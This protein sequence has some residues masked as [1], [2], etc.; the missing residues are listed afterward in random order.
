[1]AKS[2]N[3]AVFLSAETGENLDELRD[4]MY[5][6]I[7]KLYLDRYPYKASYLTDY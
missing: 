7:K 1:M 5:V 6:H 4:I 2:N 3:Q